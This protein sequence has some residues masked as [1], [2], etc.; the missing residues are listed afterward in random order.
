MG[1]EGKEVWP[2]GCD[3]SKYIVGDLCGLMVEQYGCVL[4]VGGVMRPQRFVQSPGLRMTMT[5]YTQVGTYS[6]NHMQ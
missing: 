2:L 5:M 3:Q 4:V 1:W 6:K